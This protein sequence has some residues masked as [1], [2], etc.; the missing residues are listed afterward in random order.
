MTDRRRFLTQSVAAGALVATVGVADSADNKAVEP[1][2]KAGAKRG[3]RLPIKSVIRRPETTLRLGG[4]G[5]NFHMSWADDDR[6]YVSLCDGMG[7]SGTPTDVYNSRLYALSGEPHDARF[8][9]IKNYPLKSLWLLGQGK[10]TGYFN[11]GT[12]AL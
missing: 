3:P 12:L 10:T 6:Q 5:D 7:F 8:H 2:S 11:F 4:D 1:A 9:E